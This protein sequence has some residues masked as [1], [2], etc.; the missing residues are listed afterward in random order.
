LDQ[1]PSDIEL[2]AKDATIMLEQ[3]FYIRRMENKAADLYRAK[4]INGFCHLYSG[5]VIIEL[6]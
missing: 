4:L 1:G 6:N 2:D 5:Q 3:M